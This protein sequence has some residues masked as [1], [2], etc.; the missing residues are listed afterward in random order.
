MMKD[1]GH[2]RNATA[3]LSV[4]A[5]GILAASPARAWGTRTQ[6]AA[7]DTALRVLAKEVNIPLDRREKEVK[8]G[9]GLPNEKISELYVG[10]DGNP[11]GALETEMKLL[12]HVQQG[13][14]DAYLAYRLGVIAKV[15]ADLT[16]PMQKVVPAYRNLYF[17]DVEKHIHDTQLQIRRRRSV[18]PEEYF[19]PILAEI[20]VQNLIIE[21]E[22]E[23]GPGF[24]GTAILSLPRDFSR[25]VN[26]IT[27]VW[28]TILTN[29]G[30]RRA[31]SQSQLRSYVIDAYRFY[32]HRGNKAEL[33]AVRGRLDGLMEM[34]P[35]VLVL[36]GDLYYR[37][38]MVE[39]AV[40]TYQRARALAPGRRDV[41][42]KIAAYYAQQAEDALADLKLEDALYAYD[43]AIEADPLHPNAEERRLSVAKL[44][45]ER[46]GRQAVDQEYLREGDD[47]RDR[48]SR[49]A[50][51][52]E[53]S[54]AIRELSQAAEAYSLISDEFPLERERKKRALRDISQRIREL[55]QSLMIEAKKFSGKGF[56]KGVQ[57]LA[58]RPLD[59]LDHQAL[60]KL[61]RHAYEA[62]MERL[63]NSATRV[64]A[65]E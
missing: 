15:V 27:D 34:E 41:I 39:R 13:T 24:Q 5:I 47:R 40:N 19:P 59:K 50:A 48:A 49:Q 30:G 52:G 23:D 29:A 6:F 4:L 45:A 42:E 43:R 26:A 55:K 58:Q 54:A 22:Y 17:S 62:E 10:L 38:G 37:A 56:T 44:I 51:A 60:R 20:D 57:E 32:I 25:T 14:V 36:I 53:Y 28:F 12:A 61:M 2:Y 35:D 46:D 3:L 21:Q 8:T 7:I 33:N 9:A 63:T 64:L 16:S 31:V 65:A 1:S 11:I 18:A